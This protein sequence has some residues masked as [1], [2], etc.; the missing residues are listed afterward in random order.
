MRSNIIIIR[1]RHTLSKSFLARSKISRQRRIHPRDIKSRDF[2][3]RGHTR[4]QTRG[5]V[6]KIASA[7]SRYATE[8]LKDTLNASSRLRLFFYDSSTRRVHS[9][10]MFTNVS[11]ISKRKKSLLTALSVSVAAIAE[12]K[13]KATCSHNLSTPCLQ[14]NLRCTRFFPNRTNVT[15]C[16]VSLIIRLSKVN[17]KD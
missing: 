4:S 7:R 16:D 2:R 5:V 11:R 15:V 8:K 1:R 13:V 3:V 9:F 6:K 10:L 12:R 17:R 14:R